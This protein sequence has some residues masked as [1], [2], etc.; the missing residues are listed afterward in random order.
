MNRK[1]RGKK[2]KE[3]GSENIGRQLAFCSCFIGIWYDITES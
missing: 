2:E 1:V 3:K